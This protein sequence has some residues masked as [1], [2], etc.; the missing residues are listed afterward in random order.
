M[1]R[2]EAEREAERLQAE[3]PERA[4]HHFF[5][6]ESPDGGWHVARVAI[7]DQ[8]RRPELRE[9]IESKPQPSPA[10]DPRTGHE[11]RAPGVSGGI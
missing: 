3:H 10:D 11:Q 9:T 8:L 1:T 4:T 2:D 6:R 7:P 5:A